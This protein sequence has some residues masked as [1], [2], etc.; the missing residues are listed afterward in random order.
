[1]ALIDMPDAS[2]VFRRKISNNKGQ[3]GCRVR[4]WLLA[5]D[6]GKSFSLRCGAETGICQ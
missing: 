3:S 2:W 5:G 4:W 1:M 6:D